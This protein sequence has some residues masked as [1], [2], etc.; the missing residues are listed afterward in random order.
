MTDRKQA[1]AIDGTQYSHPKNNFDFWRVLAALLVLFSH[2][3]ALLGHPEP[4]VFPQLS[5]GASGVCIFFVIS[6]FLVTQSWRL[7]PNAL[8]FVTRRLLRIWPGLIVV[9]LLS[10]FVLGPLVSNL[11]TAEY[12]RT[13]ETWR[14]L[15]TLLMNIKYELPGVFTGNPYPRAVNGSL[16]TIPVEVRWYLVILFAGAAGLLKSR[17]LLL[18]ASVILALYY[19]GIYGAMRDTKPIYFQEYGLFFLYGACLQMYQDEWRKHLVLSTLLCIGSAIVFLLLGHAFVAFWLVLPCLIVYCGTASTPFVRGFGRFG[20][21][22]Y[23]IYIYAFPVQQTIVWMTNARYPLPW[24]LALSVAMTLV[25]AFASWHLVEQ[26]AL[27]FKPRRLD[28]KT[29]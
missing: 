25:L 26:P 29:A 19:F 17:Y 9:V 2:Q 15:K 6:G 23:G 8:R 1:G 10:T 27:R 4:S 24:T 5:L 14:Y 28:R 13:E 16:W 22:S 20:D 21:L 3:F 11:S 18:V 12:F 7:D